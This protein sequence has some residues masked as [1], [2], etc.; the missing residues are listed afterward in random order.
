MSKSEQSTHPL[1]SPPV[2][3]NDL[4][5]RAN[6]TSIQWTPG[7]QINLSSIKIIFVRK[8]FLNKKIK[9]A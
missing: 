8:L 2:H 7:G 3:Q 1:L 4:M 9:N 6:K 5:T